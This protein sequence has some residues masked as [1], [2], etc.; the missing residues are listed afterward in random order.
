MRLSRLHRVAVFVTVSA[1]LF[2]SMLDSTI[3]A[4][5]LHAL[6]HGL[7]TSITWAGWTITAYSLG[8]VMMLSLS[9]KLSERYGRRRVFLISVVLFIVASLACGFAQNIY[10]LIVLRVLQAIGGAGFTPSATGIIVD[11]FGSSRDKAVGLFGSILTIGAM[12]G[13]VVGGFI[14]QYASWQWIFWVNVPIGLVLI[15][16]TLKFVPQDPKV[17][18]RTRAQIDLLGALLLAISMFGFMVGLTF[19]GSS[20][21]EM[22]WLCT[23]AFVVAIL[24]FCLFIERIRHAK[25]PIIGPKL[26]YGKGFAAVNMVNFFYIGGVAGLIALIP[27]YAITRYN[28]SVVNAGTLLAAQSAAAMILSSIAAFSL[29]RTGYRK[30]IFA[31][32]LIIIFGMI[33]LAQLPMGDLSPYMWIAIAAAIIGVGA[34]LLSP[35]SRNAGLQLV[36]KHASS[37]AALRTT[38]V[39]MGIIS[40]VSI[41]TVI[42]DHAASPSSA[43]AWIYAFFPLILLILLPIINRVP[44]HRG[45]W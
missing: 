28:I 34:G 44:E 23:V 15:P 7:H 10:L 11:Y 33:M 8:M 6:Q 5:A 12:V 37:L 40:A 43:Q 35:A 16:M 38:G 41:A 31:G 14:I 9:G 13:P 25:D 45:F 18:W 4:T 42:I 32:G 36:P 20:T 3:V 1:A 26:V 17:R 39:Q 30:P 24:M 19:L 29:R 21:P 2:M 22:V 27:L